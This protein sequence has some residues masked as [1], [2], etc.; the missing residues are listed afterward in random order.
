[1]NTCFVM[2]ERTRTL[3]PTKHRGWGFWLMCWHHWLHTKT[4]STSDDQHSL[5]C[6]CWCG[7]FAVEKEDAGCIW[8]PLLKLLKAFFKH[9]QNVLCS[10][11]INTVFSLLQNRM[12]TYIMETNKKKHYWHFLFSV[13]MWLFNDKQNCVFKRDCIET[14]WMFLS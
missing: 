5:K 7:L 11:S 12:S 3:A 13:S 9:L 1:M 14:W 4:D 6:S 2:G 8:W 10:F